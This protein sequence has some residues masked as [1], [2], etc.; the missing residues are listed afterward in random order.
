[1]KYFRRLKPFKA[2]SFDLDDTLYDNRPIIINA[3]QSSL[4]YLQGL[5]PQLAALNSQQWQQCKQQVLALQP[6]L[7]EDVTAWR[8]AAIEHLLMQLGHSKEYSSAQAQAAF[9]YFLEVRSDFSV[10]DQSVQV[11]AELSRKMPIVAITNGNVDLVRIGLGTAF[12]LVLKAG[13][14]LRAKPCPDM[15]EVAAK[16]LGIEVAD[17]LHVGDHLTTDV[18]GAKANGAQAV[19][20]NDQ[21]HNLKHHQH[22]Y[23]LPDVEIHNLN[24]LLQLVE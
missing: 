21:G 9:E 7:V 8:I 23:A 20:F 3:E 18:Y 22:T 12:S 6:Q 10:P 4:R 17:I 19:W 14:G 13:N 5:D 15:F 2:M 16:H 1:M 11:L 24:Q